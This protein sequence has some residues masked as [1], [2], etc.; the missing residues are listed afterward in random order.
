M[1]TITIFSLLLLLTSISFA[2]TKNADNY[3]PF[4][5]KP[6]TAKYFKTGN[7]Y[8]LDYF[9][10]DK[11]KFGEYEYYA[12]IRMYSW[13]DTDTTYYREDDQNYYHFDPKVDRESIVL[14]KTITMGQKWLE[15]D[16]SWSYEIIGIEEK[17][18]TPVKKYKGLIVIEC[19]QLTG[20]D[21]NKSKVYH[22]YYAKGL[23]FIGSVNNGDLRS[24]LAEVKKNAK[25]GE[26]IGK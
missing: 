12:K 21:K 11:Y 18:Q 7:N 22:L 6:N 25:D 16:S 4:Y 14:P 3:L 15:A 5:D 13:G 17:L 1:N 19:I 23:G 2:Q 8:Y 10:S 26:I 20:R 24:Y 9:L